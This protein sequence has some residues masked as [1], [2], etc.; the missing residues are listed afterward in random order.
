MAV[1]GRVKQ[2]VHTKNGIPF[3]GGPR[4]HLI[5]EDGKEDPE[6]T[7]GELVNI[8]QETP[9]SLGYHTVL[10]ETVSELLNGYCFHV[11]SFLEGRKADIF[12]KQLSDKI[13]ILQLNTVGIV[14]LVLQS[15]SNAIVGIIEVGLIGYNFRANE[16]KSLV[17]FTPLKEKA[18]HYLY[19]SFTLSKMIMDENL[20]DITLKSDSFSTVWGG[21]ELAVPE[22]F[23]WNKSNDYSRFFII[24][25]KRNGQ[26]EE[27]SSFDRDIFRGI[28]NQIEIKIKSIWKLEQ[29]KRSFRETLKY[30]E[31][32]LF[33]NRNSSTKEMCDHF[34]NN[35]RQNLLRADIYVG[36]LQS[37]GADSL[38]YISCNST[39]KMLGRK[40]KRKEVISYE[41]M[42]TLQSLIFD[43]Q[44]LD[45]KKMLYDG[46]TVGILYGKKEYSGKIVKFRGH[47][48]Y[49]VRYDFDNK[50]KHT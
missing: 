25:H 36:L 2:V 8:Y 3:F 42:E 27:M 33:E 39:S 28:T 18:S 30:L 24:L 47:D 23:S 29:R 31:T 1:S 26:F 21:M 5:W 41:I 40:L 22:H 13:K 19:S 43:N 50:I 6:V 37:G 38:E 46:A 49:D 11:G 48:L 14:E 16:M 12:L 9:Q 35:I 4:F 32:I 45:K 10:N 34:V 15:V 20:T 17:S 7:V 44:D